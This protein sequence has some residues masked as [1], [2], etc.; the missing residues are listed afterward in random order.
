MN[1]ELSEQELKALIE[2]YHIE[3]AYFSVRGAYMGCEDEALVD[4]LKAQLR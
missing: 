1:M 3:D 2:W 4:K